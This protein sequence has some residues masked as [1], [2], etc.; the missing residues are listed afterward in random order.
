MAYELKAWMSFKS[1][2]GAIEED[3][4]SSLVWSPF[5]MLTI[6]DDGFDYADSDYCPP[7]YNHSLN[8]EVAVTEHSD[9]FTIKHTQY[10]PIWVVPADLTSDP[11]D[12]CRERLRDFLE[13]R[14]SLGFERL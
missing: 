4:F 11:F 12:T 6:I 10:D 7:R 8:I 1:G 14:A 13:Y 2:G 3:S 9:G 5:Q